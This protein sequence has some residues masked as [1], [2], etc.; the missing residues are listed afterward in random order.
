MKMLFVILGLVGAFFLVGGENL[1]T[2]SMNAA[3]AQVAQSQSTV[4][5]QPLDVV[6]QIKAA[7]DLTWYENLQ[8]ADLV[9]MLKAAS[10]SVQK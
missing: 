1:V 6:Q 8:K 7:M 5:G 9:T 3:T 4:E 2:G 10:G